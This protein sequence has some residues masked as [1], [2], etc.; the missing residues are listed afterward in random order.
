MG[1]NIVLEDGGRHRHA[2]TITEALCVHHVRSSKCNDSIRKRGPLDSTAAGSGALSIELAKQQQLDA[3]HQE[4]GQEAGSIF[5]AVGSSGDSLESSLPAGRRRAGGGYSVLV[6]H[7]EQ[8]WLGLTLSTTRSGDDDEP[9]GG[10]DESRDDKDDLIRHAG[11]D[12]T[13]MAAL[14]VSVVRMRTVVVLKGAGDGVCC[15]PL[16]CEMR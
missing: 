13:K 16:L 14:Q 12:S 9:A 3:V 15:S 1:G 5:A 6:Q 11:P 4:A 7:Q 10:E 2:T 8:W